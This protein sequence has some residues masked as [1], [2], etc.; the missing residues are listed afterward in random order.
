[1]SASL[2]YVVSVEFLILRAFV[3]R[4]SF[5]F[6]IQFTNYQFQISISLSA[7]LCALRDLCGGP[8][9]FNYNLQ[10]INFKF[11]LTARI[12]IAKLNSI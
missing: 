11:Y 12:V 5:G 2:F 8:L 9:V 6:Q 4:L 7:P 3:V 1:V 10:I